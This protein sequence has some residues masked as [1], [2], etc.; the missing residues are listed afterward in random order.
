MYDLP[1][2][3]ERPHRLAARPFYPNVDLYSALVYRKLGI[4]ATVRD[5]AIPGGGL[6]C[7]LKEQLIANQFTATQSI[8]HFAEAGPGIPN[9]RGAVNL[10]CTGSDRI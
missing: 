2:P 10:A 4:P 5:F 1:S 3:E 6:G 8:T 7:P 9:C